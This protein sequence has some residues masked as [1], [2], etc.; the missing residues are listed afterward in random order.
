MTKHYFDT[1]GTGLLNSYNIDYSQ[2][3]Y[4]IK[5]HFKLHCVSF[6][7]D[8]TDQFIDFVGENCGED[9]IKYIEENV[10][11]I[12]GHN[13]I[14]HDL[15]VL[16]AFCGLDYEVASNKQE[17]DYINGKPIKITDTYIL[18]KLYKP[19][20]E[21][22]GMGYYG[23]LLG[24]AKIDWRQKAIDLGLI[25]KNSPKGAEFL[26]YHPEMLVYC[27][28]D[29][30]VN[31]LADR[32][33]Q[34]EAG[35]WDWTDAIILEKAVAELTTRQEHFGFWFDTDLAYSL[36][37]DLDQ[38]LEERRLI[39]EPILPRKALTKAELEKWTPPARQLLYEQA[40]QVPKV[41][42]KKD[43]SPSQAMLRYA[44]KVG[45][46][47]ENYDLYDE[48][49]KE[50]QDVLW[51]RIGDSL[52]SFSSM[53]PLEQ[54][55]VP[56]YC[57][58][59][60]SSN[61]ENWVQKHDGLLYFADDNWFAN[62]NGQDYQLPIPCEPLYKDKAGEIKDSTH[63]KGWLV[64][65]GWHPL[66]FKERDLTVDSKKRKKT[67]EKFLKSVE[68][69][70]EQTLASPFKRDRFEH[71]EVRTE[72]QFRDK[73]LNH[74]INRP[75]KVLSNPVFTTGQDKELDPNLVLLSE[76]FPYAKEVVD[77]LTYNHRRNSIASNGYDPLAE[78]SDD[79]EDMEDTT[80]V[81]TDL[82]KSGFLSRVRIY[83]D[84]RIETPANTLGAA[85]GR[86]T[87]KVVCNIA[88]SS[89]LYGAE[90]R[91]LFGVTQGNYQLGFDFSSL[92]ARIESHYTYRYDDSEH[93]YVNSLLGERPNDVH[94]LTAKKITEVIGT[95][96]PRQSAKSVKY[97]CLNPSTTRV[98]TKDKG[99]VYVVDLQIGDEVL[100]Y[101]VENQEYVHTPIRD[102][103][104]QK[105]DLYRL[106]LSETFMVDCTLDH[107]WLTQ[108]GYVETQELVNKDFIVTAYNQQISCKQMSLYKVFENV[109]VF[110]LMTD[111][112]N[113]FIQ[114]FYSGRC[115]LTGNC[116]YGAMPKKLAKTI[117]CSIEIATLI[118]EGFWIAAC[119]LALLKERLEVY[120]EKIGQK[121]FI[122]GLD[123]RKIYT[124]SK[125]AL[126]N[127]L[128][129]SGGVICTKRASVILD[130]MLREKGLICDFW[131]DDY[132]NRSFA[133]LMIAYHDECQ[134]ELTKDLLETRLFPV[135]EWEYDKK[136]NPFSSMV[137]QQ[138]KDFCAENPAWS[139]PHQTSEG[140]ELSYSIVGALALQ[141]VGQAGVYYKLNVPLTA[142]YEVGANWSQCH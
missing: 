107:M 66:S 78:D 88:R 112:N 75:L 53:V 45:G 15:L 98:V 87:H 42:I 29:I 26:V 77:W 38:K 13:I 12:V 18:S 41:Q 109:D 43:G 14:A 65:A 63:I 59:T 55:T 130:R 3:P 90:M 83:Q 119:P 51:L 8:A 123:G 82:P 134:I 67:E 131:K 11:E 138:I 89:S 118:W 37:Q 57:T 20:R 115:T 58:P 30:R 60:L 33:L 108:R 140:Y 10:T 141:A 105:E 136:G 24:S 132:R 52:Y 62:I 40:P 124:R 97:A 69:Y 110:C 44:E 127:Y 113:F 28:Q 39:V 71:L 95:D 56:F 61:I 96:F 73:L 23:D 128:F 49:Q 35:D 102:I 25:D 6:L 86:Y 5:P 16:K 101:D 54:D 116:S 72:K 22:H 142:E 120:W 137:L 92:E 81:P 99:I 4:K 79:D 133:Q 135:T 139:T 121:K 114:S 111:Y 70:I 21:G 129:Q 126:I 117:G 104:K 9:A 122:L 91:S 34:E 2:S 17:Q 1:E 100:A 106:K 50:A 36:V 85:S 84:H 27:Q 93:T 125:S 76:S 48:K 103:I 68:L 64:E 46:T 47:I 19:D 74:N 32:Y 31:R 80:D 7:N 94:T